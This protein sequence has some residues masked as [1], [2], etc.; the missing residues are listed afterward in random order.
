MQDKFVVHSSSSCSDH[1]KESSKAEF[2]F[3]GFKNFRENLDMIFTPKQLPSWKLVVMM[4]AIQR[5]LEN[6]TKNG[7][8][9]PIDKKLL[10]LFVSEE[11]NEDLMEELKVLTEQSLLCGWKKR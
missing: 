1:K 8:I 5:H 7:V 4:G 2:R 10:T 3:E 6:L 9:T 11:Q